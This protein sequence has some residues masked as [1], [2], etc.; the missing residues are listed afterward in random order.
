MLKKIAYVEI[1]ADHLFLSWNLVLF[2][3]IEQYIPEQNIFNKNKAKNKFK[4]DA[5]QK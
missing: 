2:K 4:I 5:R 3:G 1:S